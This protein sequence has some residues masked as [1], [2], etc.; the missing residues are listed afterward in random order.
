M[1]NGLVLRVTAVCLLL[2]VGGS[3][4]C[5]T[6][7]VTWPNPGQSGG[8]ATCLTLDRLGNPCVAYVTPGTPG[9]SVMFARRN[10][11]SWEQPETIASGS[12]QYPS[13]AVDSGGGAHFAYRDWAGQCLTYSYWN[14][15]DGAPIS[16]VVDSENSAGYYADIALDSS[17]RPSIAYQATDH[18][19]YAQY[20]GSAWDVTVVENAPSG[21]GQVTSLALDQ[22]GYAHISYCNEAAQV[23]MYATNEGGSW[24][25]NT[26][27]ASG[28]VGEDSSIALD[29]NGLPHIAYWDRTRGKLRYAS[30]TGSQSSWDITEVDSV[31]TGDHL[32]AS[33]AFDGDDRPHISYWDHEDRDLRYAS[34]D[35]SV[36]QLETVDAAGAV[37]MSS[38]LVVDGQGNAH[39]SYYD[40]SNGSLKYAEEQSG[41]T[42]E[43]S[44]WAL[45]ACSGLF[46][47]GLLRRRRTA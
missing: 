23:L 2:G 3:A 5:S 9:G 28:Y 31:A 21:W 27:D 25:T 38:S 39:I 35:G 8:V 45:L 32:G 42:P 17:G 41:P 37:G 29:S 26:V 7:D 44:T 46:G 47:V 15:T 34:W 19:R 4:W 43:L 12:F 24:T 16:T 13:L 14:G 33:L 11:S 18:L 36:W 22:D 40:E 20:N 6:W 1:R 30:W 10:G